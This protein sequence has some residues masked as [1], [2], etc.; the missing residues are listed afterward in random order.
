MNNQKLEIQ[1]WTVAIGADVS[2]V[3]LATIDAETFAEV[4][5]ALH[6]H[7]VLFFHD[8]NLSPETHMAF[9]ARLG[10]MEIHEVFTPLE[11]HQRFPCLNTTPSARR[12]VIHGIRT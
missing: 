4:K 1:T 8:Q 10:D 3:D 7:L 11:N 9:A 12:S 5:S 6:E 2:G